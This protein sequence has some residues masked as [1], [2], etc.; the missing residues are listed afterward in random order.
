MLELTLL[1]LRVLQIDS[2]ISHA[3]ATLGALVLQRST[4]GGISSKIT[5][6]SSRLPTVCK[7]N[8]FNVAYCFSDLV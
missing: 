1:H 5:N 4:F 2:V 8:Q 7:N 6:V 3:Q